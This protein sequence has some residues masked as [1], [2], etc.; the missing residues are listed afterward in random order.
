MTKP[1][2]KKPSAKK[3]ARRKAKS[4]VEWRLHYMGNPTD[5]LVYKTRGRAFAQFSACRY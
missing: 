3:P 5:A 2:R 1:A 4:W